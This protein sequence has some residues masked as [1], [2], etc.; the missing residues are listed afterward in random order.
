MNY[1]QK[2]PKAY[3]DTKNTEINKDIYGNDLQNLISLSLQ[4]EYN[5]RLSADY[6]FKKFKN[7][8]KE[9]RN[10][11][12]LFK[13][14]SEDPVIKNLI[15]EINIRDSLNYI[16]YK[17]LES[18]HISNENKSYWGSLLTCFLFGSMNLYGA[19][20]GSY[21]F[22][23]LGGIVVGNISEKL[24]NKIFS[25]KE[26]ERFIYQNTKIIEKIQSFLFSK[27]FDELL[28]ANIIENKKITI[29]NKESFRN[30]LI[31]VKE[32]LI[33]VE[34]ISK[35]TNTFNVLSVGATNVE[36]S[37]LINDFFKLKG[38]ERAKESMGGPTDTK[39]FT[40]YNGIFNKKYYSLFDT[41]GI[42]NEGNDSIENKIKNTEN[43]LNKRIKGKDPNSLIHCIWYCIQGSNIQPS[44]GKFIKS[45]INIYEK[46]SMPIIF[47]HTL[48]FSKPQSNKCK[49]WVE[50]YLL[51]I[52]NNNRTIVDSHLK[53]YIDIL[54]RVYEGDLMKPFGLVELENLT[55]KEIEEKGLKSAYYEYI[56]ND[57]LPILINGAFSLIFNDYN[58]NLLKNYVT[59][60]LEN[61]KK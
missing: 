12:I 45:L 17:I 22:A 40:Q 54:S 13:I 11:F 19:G 9:I 59:K 57:I 29:Y 2:K 18:Q 7:E 49:M 24:I 39:D 48:T 58:L 33:S 52:Y 26:K 53:N 34:Y 10:N 30:N 8:A 43:E 25:L 3:H 28:D 21:F 47:A 61:Y 44:D 32:K 41:N 60:D 42:T 46:Y 5:K 4:K 15:I 38:N 55:R 27:I 36:K 50:K 37:S 31:S 51:E 6:I 20:L 1:V 14:L 16:G 23:A 56:K 35:L